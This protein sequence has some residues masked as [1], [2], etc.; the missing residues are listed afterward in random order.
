MN[1]QHN[2]PIKD[3]LLDRIKKG[4]VVMRPKFHFTLK[5]LATALVAFAVLVIS[6]F[7]FNFILFSI[8]I[9]HHDT[10][11]SFGVDGLV[12]FLFFFPWLLLLV[13]ILLIALLEWLL[14]QF[15]FGYTIP[16]LYLLAGI[17]VMTA[18][19]G[20]ALDRGTPF[21]DRMI[22]RARHLPAPVGDFYDGAR[23]PWRKGSGLCHCE[24]VS[25]DENRLIASDL[26]KGT[27]TLQVVL[28]FD[29]DRAT[30]TGLKV[31]DVVL[32]AGREKEGTL[33]AFGIHKLDD[34]ELP[35]IRD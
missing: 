15:R 28:P 11:L 21:N 12:A 32:I 35:R 23:K 7:I 4:E 1:E 30:T 27:T 6:V 34:E 8:R 31:G 20:F 26:R 18:V 16:V 19:T 3:Q 10:L 2:E 24:I 5:V 22:E 9:N 14:R 17:V 13:D 29:D 33:Y 25:I